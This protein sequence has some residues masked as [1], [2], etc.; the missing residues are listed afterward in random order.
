M[1]AYTHAEFQKLPLLPDNRWLRH[2]R[3]KNKEMQSPKG[4]ALK[5]PE[6]PFSPF[7]FNLLREA[8]LFPA[9][10][11]GYPILEFAPLD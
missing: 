5:V 1:N 11:I 7:Q 9:Q 10:P 3:Q 4:K 2:D 6:Y 8:A